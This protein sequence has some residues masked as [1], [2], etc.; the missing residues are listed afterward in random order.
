MKFLLTHTA[1]SK[2]IDPPVSLEVQPEPRS[3]YGLNCQCRFVFRVAPE[4][5]A[6]LVERRLVLGH[7]SAEASFVCGCLG[8]LQGRP[9]PRLPAL[10]RPLACLDIEGTSLEITES[11]IVE[12]A[13]VVLYPDGRRTEWCSR[14]NPT[15]EIPVSATEVHG[16]VNADVTDKPTF[17]SMAEKIHRGLQGKD[18]CGYNLW[19][20]DLGVL[21]CELRR[22]GHK[23]DLTGVSVI[24]VFGIYS[25]KDPRNLE[26]AI[27]KY[28]GRSH[29]G[30][31]GALPDAVGTLDTL[32]AQL[33][34]YPDLAGMSLDELVS[35]SLRS[36]NRPADLCG[37]LSYDADGFMVYNFGKN[38]GARVKDES[39]F[40]FWMKRQNFPAS[41]IE[42]LDAEL[43]RHE[44][45]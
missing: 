9:A 14:F 4:S 28:C 3:R 34:E 29:E 25:N 31:H 39:G 16:I 12:L 23:L 19:G 21:D 6:A 1:Q 10:V 41:T 5:V 38:R 42:V 32:C 36:D 15:V 26:A 37:K 7:Q 24:D 45:L 44:L 18:L 11:R 2:P 20:Y 40:A 13:V 35:A 22:S 8:V 17:A 43:R 30:A 33:G 27:R